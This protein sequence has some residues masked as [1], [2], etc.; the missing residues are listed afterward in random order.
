MDKTGRSRR[1]HSATRWWSKFFQQV[2]LYFGFVE[3][4]LREN[5][6]ICK[7][8]RVQLLKIFDNPQDAQDLRLELAAI[9]DAGVH[10]V[11]ATD[12]LEGDG[13]LLFSC[14]ER[15]LAVFRAVSVEHYPNTAAVARQ[16]AD[17]DH[18]RYQQLMAQD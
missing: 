10:S 18:A 4:F 15:L 16:I 8:S 11:S 2:L 17:G 12:F 7:L 1:S 13:P 3:P 6:E 5:E 14:Y 9:I